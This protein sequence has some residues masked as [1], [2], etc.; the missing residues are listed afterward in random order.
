MNRFFAGVITVLI[1]TMGAWAQGTQAPGQ[2]PT[3]SEQTGAESRQPDYGRDRSP[4]S[5]QSA[6][7]PQ[8]QTIQGTIQNVDTVGNN[9][10]V[11][12][13]NGQEQ[14]LTLDANTSIKVNG[15]A[16]AI[17]DVK[18]G[19]QATATINGQKAVALDATDSARGMR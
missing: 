15:R 9:V 2:P 19:Q 11:R 17:G 18:T 5:T 3:E 7:G 4:L 14:V 16:A 8:E 12:T 13:H 1:V 10:T 6:A